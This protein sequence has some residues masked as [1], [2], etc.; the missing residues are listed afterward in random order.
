MAD[1]NIVELVILE[2]GFLAACIKKSN[3]RTAQ[4]QAGKQRYQHVKAKREAEPI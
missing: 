4:I 3:P 1:R 2:N